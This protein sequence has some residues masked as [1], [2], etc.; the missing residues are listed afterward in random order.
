M[1]IL[2]AENE[3]GVVTE[4]QFMILVELFE[5][6]KFDYDRNKELVK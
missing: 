4:E 6:G 3:S 2:V 1:G 5:R